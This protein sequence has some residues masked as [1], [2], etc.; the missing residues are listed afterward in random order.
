[1]AERRLHLWQTGA[2]L[3]RMRAV[4]VPQPMRRD[5]R[6]DAGLLCRTF[7]HVVHAALGKPGAALTTCEYRIVGAGVAVQR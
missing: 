6:I 1:M 4:G 2:T 3:D 7:H 5:L